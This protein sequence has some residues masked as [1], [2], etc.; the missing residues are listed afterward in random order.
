MWVSNPSRSPG[1]SLALLFCCALIVPCAPVSAQS[2]CETAE[3][4]YSQRN[5]DQAITAAQAL[6]TDPT[7]RLKVRMCAYKVLRKSCC[8]K[9][10]LCID[11]AEIYL[12]EIDRSDPE[13]DLGP[14]DN[15]PPPCGALLGKLQRKWTRDHPSPVPT[16]VTTLA[17]LP[18]A[19]RC[20]RLDSA[21]RSDLHW[22]LADILMT[23]LID[24]EG[25]RL[26]E[27]ERIEALLAQMGLTDLGIIDPETA[28]T[29][30]GILGAQS[31]SLGS[32]NCLPGKK[33]SPFTRLV[34]T[35]TGQIFCAERVDGREDDLLELMGELGK[36]I[37]EAIRD[38]Y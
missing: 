36:K 6:L 3:E 32:Y 31:V 9:M 13:Y 11:S 33:I 29:I 18:F 21:D 23:D 1:I 4:H 19:V 5:Y 26:V 22:G 16:D 12:R 7:A 17:I 2:S 24:L 25:L 35:E 15:W 30:G 37:V 14:D 38:G 34:K 8:A 20:S 27:R 28:V 10:D